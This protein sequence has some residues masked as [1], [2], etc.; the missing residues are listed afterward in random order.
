M[1]KYHNIPPEQALT[2]R[3]VDKFN[4]DEAI[5][6]KLRSHREFRRRIYRNVSKELHY[7]IDQIEFA[8][9]KPPDDC[10]G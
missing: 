7:I 9:I 3:L 1:Q 8:A 4:A 5:W 10:V 6:Q 2:Q